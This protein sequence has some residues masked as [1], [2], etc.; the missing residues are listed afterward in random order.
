[1]EEAPPGAWRTRVAIHAASELGALGE[2]LPVA[3][4]VGAPAFS[5]SSWGYS[6]PKSRVEAPPGAVRLRFVAAVAAAV[7]C[8]SSEAAPPRTML[9]R[10]PGACW[11]RRAASGVPEIDSFDADRSWNTDR[12]SSV[13]NTTASAPP[14]GPR[15]G[16]G[17]GIPA[18][19]E[20]AIVA[21]P[22]GA[23]EKRGAGSG[24]TTRCTCRSAYCL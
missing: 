10:P 17:G 5:K 13:P 21:E 3:A 6:P 16:S 23:C 2:G 19:G 18:A 14:T 22:P 20:K 1:M 15:V 12:G 7:A 24:V 8:S 11:K 4:V 9:D